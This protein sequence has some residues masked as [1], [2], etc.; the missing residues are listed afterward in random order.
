[1]KKMK[2]LFVIDRNTNL[3]IN[4][5]R[6]ECAWVLNGEGKATIKFDGT[7]AIFMNGK[8]Y[9]RWDRKLKKKFARMKNRLGNKFVAKE[10]MFKEVPVGAIPCQAPDPV[11]FHQPHW[12]LVD[13]KPENIW[14]NE[15]L[16]TNPVLVEGASYELVGEKVQNNVYDIKGHELWQHGSKEVEILDLT[17]EGLKKWL[18]ENVGEGLVFHHPDGRMCKL[19]RKDFGINWNNESLRK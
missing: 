9:K 1:M 15:A 4:E 19:R 14:F 16:K 18:T 13:D 12:V 11:T 10:H 8:L 2:T 6:E 17:F 7:A 5:V 3:A